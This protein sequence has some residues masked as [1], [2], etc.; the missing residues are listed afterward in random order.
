MS[1][2]AIPPVSQR[3]GSKLPSTQTWR[4]VSSAPTQRVDLSV[5]PTSTPVVPSLGVVPSDPSSSLM[6]PAPVGGPEASTII[7][8]PLGS[9][10]DDAHAQGSGTA[11]VVVG[12]SPVNFDNTSADHSLPSL[13]AEVIEDAPPYG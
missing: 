6:V 10:V 5:S 9:S 3:P 4:Q 13:G 1:S 7:S 11:S 8:A 2:S 12:P